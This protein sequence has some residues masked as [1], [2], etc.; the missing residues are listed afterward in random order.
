MQTDA[1]RFG[2]LKI[3][4]TIGDLL[5]FLETSDMVSAFPNLGQLQV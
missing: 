3:A 2:Y 4:C 5:E 1:P